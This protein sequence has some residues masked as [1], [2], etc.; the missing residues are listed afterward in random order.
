MVIYPGTVD[1]PQSGVVITISEDVWRNPDH[2]L[3][4][5]RSVNPMTGESNQ[6]GEREISAIYS[7]FYQRKSRKVVY[8]ELLP[9]GMPLDSSKTN[10]DM[11]YTLSIDV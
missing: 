10:P 9:E 2:F 5:D 7:Q 8:N 4:S 6:K 3:V 11:G 1:I